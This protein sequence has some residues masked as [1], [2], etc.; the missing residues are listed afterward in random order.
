MRRPDPEPVLDWEPA[1]ARELGH[2]V[3]ELWEEY[4]TA[5]PDLP[6]ARDRTPAEV[7]S[8]VTLPVP[9]EGLDTTALMAALRRVVLEESTQVGHGGFMAYI[10]GA[11]TVPGAAAA[12]VGAAINQNAGGWVLG[13]AATEIETA[14]IEAFAAGFGLPASASGAFVSGGATANLVALAAARD[15]R[16]GWD[17]RSDGVAAGPPLAVYASEEVHDTVDR[18]ADLLGLGAG[19]VRRIPVD[20]RLRVRPDA[21]A[22]A[23]E[24]DLEAGIRPLCIVGTAGTTGTGS[25]DPLSPL[26]DLA[27]EHGCWF[28]VDAAYGGPAAL[29]PE[30]TPAFAGMD[31]ADSVTCDPHKWLNTPIASSIVLFRDAQ[32]QWDAFNLEPDYTRQDPHGDDNGLFRYQWTPSFTRPFDALTVW[33]SLLAHGWDAYRRRIRHDVELARWLHHLVSQHEELEAVLDPELSIVC[34]R[35]VPPGTRDEG[36]A[37]RALDRLNERI[38]FALRRQGRVFPSNATVDGRYTLR[39]CIM[40]YRTEADDVEALVTE[41]VRLGR[42]LAAAA[43]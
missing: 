42:E 7:A 37:A 39:A 4:L 40:S 34:F 24:R 36:D 11:G 10:S 14:V 31:R 3:V 25:I 12:L 9:D 17:V 22:D 16:A 15:T 32:T 27:A 35:Y 8:A 29:V 5:L 6:V 19:A 38:A 13:P 20:R 41:T 26:A 21:L 23:V 28:H 33:V 43:A 2:A 1:R 18:A 30:L